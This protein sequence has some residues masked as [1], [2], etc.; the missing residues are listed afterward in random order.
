[1]KDLTFVCKDC[2]AD[3]YDMLDEVRERCHVCQWLADI[4]DEAERT[5]ARE[6]LIEIGEIDDGPAPC[7]SVVTPA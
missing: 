5:K 7:V 3:V 4:P 6:W 2:G 1:M